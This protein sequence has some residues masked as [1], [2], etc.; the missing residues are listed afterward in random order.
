MQNELKSASNL[1]IEAKNRTR[2]NSQYH[3]YN[4]TLLQSNAPVFQECPGKN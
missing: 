3:G 2:R 4:P 1:V